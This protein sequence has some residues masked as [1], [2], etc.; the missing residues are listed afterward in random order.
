MIDDDKGSL[1]GSS[2]SIDRPE[3]DFEVVGGAEENIGIRI[4]ADRI[5]RQTV[6]RGGGGRGG[7]G[8][9]EKHLDGMTP[10]DV[11]KSDLAAVCPVG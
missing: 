3:S 9:G 8:A 7:G 5:S 2:D 6:E 11:P 10:S 4:D 1:L